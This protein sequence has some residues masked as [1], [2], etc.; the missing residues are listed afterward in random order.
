[1]G[2]LGATKLGFRTLNSNSIARPPLSNGFV[3][4]R[5]RFSRRQMNGAHP[6]VTTFH[7]SPTFQVSPFES[8][9]TR[10]GDFG[11]GLLFQ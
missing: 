9:K 1:M 5:R 3:W 10:V 8:R 7:C 2:L 6:G 11:T 4:P